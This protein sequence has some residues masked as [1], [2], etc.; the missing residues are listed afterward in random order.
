MRSRLVPPKQRCIP[1]PAQS[2]ERC[3]KLAIKD[4]TYKPIKQ[5]VVV[6]KTLRTGEACK[7]C[8]SASPAR[9]IPS[10]VAN[11]GLLPPPTQ[12][13]QAK[14]WAILL[15]LSTNPTKMRQTPQKCDG[16]RPCVRCVEASEAFSCE[17][18]IVGGPHSL[19][20]QRKFVFWNDPYRSA[21]KEVSAQDRWAIEGEASGSMT[22]SQIATITQPAPE[23]VPPAVVPVDLFGRIDSLSC[24][25]PE[26]RP[27]RGVNE[28]ETYRRSPVILPPFSMLLSPTP[29]RISPEPH[30]TLFSLGAERFQ[31]S[32]AALGELDMK[33]YVP[34]VA[35][36]RQV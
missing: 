5:R 32:D 27:Q 1:G 22:N 8:R 17:Y 7:R 9:S 30:V 28:I 4:C 25:S 33:L 12:A 3:T 18:E 16:K 2:C 20:G 36:H 13:E 35:D 6:G 14:R 34:W 10:A 19:L 23:E 29:L 11:I 21:S 31:L 15:P 24:A 26:P